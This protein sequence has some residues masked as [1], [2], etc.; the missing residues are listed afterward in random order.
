MEK[1][2]RYIHIGIIL[3]TA[4]FAAVALCAALFCGKWHCLL[5]AAMLGGLTWVGIYSIREEQDD[6][7]GEQGDSL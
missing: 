3:I 6:V 7:A 1:T 5:T 2:L 4:A